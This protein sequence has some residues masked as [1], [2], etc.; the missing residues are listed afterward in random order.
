MGIAQR[1]LALAEIPQALGAAKVAKATVPQAAGAATER[2][3]EVLRQL[4]E[5]RQG[6]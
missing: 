6:R 3:V 5:A 2:V 4:H 1:E